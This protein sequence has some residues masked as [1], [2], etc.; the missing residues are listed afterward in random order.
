MENV[1]DFVQRTFVG[2]TW[3]RVR[4]S[5]T[6][7]RSSFL[8]TSLVSKDLTDRVVRRR[9]QSVLACK[10]VRDTDEKTLGVLFTFNK[11]HVI[12][13]SHSK[14]LAEWK[15]FVEFFHH[16]HLTKIF[17]FNLPDG[18]VPHCF[19][20]LIPWRKSGDILSLTM[21]TVLALSNGRQYSSTNMWH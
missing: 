12:Q 3:C 11:P 16:I 17:Q 10:R 8:C 18:H 15:P 13:G 9:A 7:W 21:S 4:T 14:A 1:D 2:K 6:P 19:E 5:S 20:V